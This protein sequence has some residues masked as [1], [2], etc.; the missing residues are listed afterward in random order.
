[1]YSVSGPNCCFIQAE[2]EKRLYPSSVLTLCGVCTLVLQV[3]L[4]FC[5]ITLEILVACQDEKH[6]ESEYS[7]F[8]ASLY[9]LSVLFRNAASM[10]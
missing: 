5:S 8:S 7:F 10:V 9:L 6:K 2:V 4:W 1:M 3:L